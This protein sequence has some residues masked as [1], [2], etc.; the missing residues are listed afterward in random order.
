[1]FEAKSPEQY[2]Y[3]LSYKSDIYSIC[4]TIVELWCGKIWINN[5]CD[6]KKN[7][8]EIMG[9]L[10]L[11]NKERFKAYLKHYSYTNS[12]FYYSNLSIIYT[13]IC[14]LSLSILLIAWHF[15]I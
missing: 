7:R 14:S 10:R 9:S 13:E 12:S 1:M 11:L 4:V 15:T 6:F 5:T 2:E 3:R 8:N